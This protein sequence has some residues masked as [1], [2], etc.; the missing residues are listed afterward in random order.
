VNDLDDPNQAHQGPSSCVMKME[1]AWH[2][3]A[4]TLEWTGVFLRQQRADV[5]STR[6]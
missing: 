6:V 1:D 3:C 5:P 2:R 4:I